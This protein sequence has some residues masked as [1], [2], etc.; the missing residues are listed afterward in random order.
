MSCWIFAPVLL[1]VYGFADSCVVREMELGRVCRAAQGLEPQ[2]KAA[3][4]RV[5]PQCVRCMLCSVQV[6]HVLCA[7][8]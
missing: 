7:L 4:Q 1:G 8:W 2:R 3:P 5:A 6:A